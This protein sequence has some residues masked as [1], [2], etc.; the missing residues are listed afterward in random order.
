[1]RF[2]IIIIAMSLSTLAS[3]S[4][5]IAQKEQPAPALP[6]ED[7]NAAEKLNPSWYRRTLQTLPGRGCNQWPQHLSGLP[8]TVSVASTLAA[9]IMSS[10][11]ALDCFHVLNP[12]A[13]VCAAPLARFHAGRFHAS[14]F[15]TLFKKKPFATKGARC[16]ALTAQTLGR[17]GRAQLRLDRSGD[18]IARE[19]ARCRLPLHQVNRGPRRMQR[20][21]SA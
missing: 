17:A 1:M 15:L 10:A 19:H 4:T 6:T 9:R 7:Q 11:P 2:F 5:A 16:E 20:A 8:R 14:L 12:S 21:K 3:G 13:V 18:L